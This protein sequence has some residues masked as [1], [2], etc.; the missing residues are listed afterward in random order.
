MAGVPSYFQFHISVFHDVPQIVKFKNIYYVN[1]T[2]SPV[3]FV[4]PQLRIHSCEAKKLTYRFSFSK[5]EKEIIITSTFLSRFNFPTCTAY[6]FQPICGLLTSSSNVLFS[7]SLF[8]ETLQ[9]L[10]SLPSLPFSLGVTVIGF[11]VPLIP[12]EDLHVVKSNY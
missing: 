7:R 5:K 10:T 11:W 4:F 2:I 9:M 3:H 6:P 12:L 8:E 1:S